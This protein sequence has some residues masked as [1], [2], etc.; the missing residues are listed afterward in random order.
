MIEIETKFLLTWYLMGFLGKRNP[1]PKFGALPFTVA[2]LDSVEE[3][4]SILRKRDYYHDYFHAETYCHIISELPM[5]IQFSV[6][7][8]LSERV[9]LPDGQLW[10]I[11]D[12]DIV[13]ADAI[14]PKYSESDY[15]RLIS[16]RGRFGGRSPEEIR[17]KKGDIIEM[18]TPIAG[19]G[20][21]VELAV[22]VDTPPTKEDIK[23]RM[24]L[25]KNKRPP[26]HL[27]DRGFIGA[28]FGSY[29]DDYLVISDCTLKDA[30]LYPTFCPTHYAMKPRFEISPEIRTQMQ[31]MFEKYEKHGVEND[32]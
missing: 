30:Y 3:A 15:N 21:S 5:G 8:S 29:D 14:S 32:R 28:R 25:Y 26:R 18:F 27:R 22:V 4:E 7:E 6:G 17:F 19:R 24:A 20:G 23:E 2:L 31:D 11:R 9:Y 1:Y 13:I 12:H 10:G 16:T